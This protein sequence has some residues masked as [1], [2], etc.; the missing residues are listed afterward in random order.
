MAMHACCFVSCHFVARSFK[1]LSASLVEPGE[2]MLTD[3]AKFERPALLH[4]GFQALDAF[5]VRLPWQFASR[6]KVLK[7][8]LVVAG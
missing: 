1:P 4:V 3:Y 8:A 5:R 6:W 2:L 7:G